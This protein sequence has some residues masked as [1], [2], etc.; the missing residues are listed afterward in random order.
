MPEEK[1]IGKRIA[2]G[3]F[4]M[5]AARWS[6]RGIGIISTIILARLLSPS[7]FGVVAISMLIVGFVEVLADTGLA[8]SLIRHPDPKPSHFNTVWTLQILLGALIAII[9]FI[10]APAAATYFG[11]DRLVAVIRL[12][13]LR[14]LLEGFENPGIIWFRRNMEFNMDFKLLVWR[15][16]I[17]FFLGIALAL[18]LRDYW[19]LVYAMISAKI[20]AVGLSYYF[21]P[22]RPRL[23]LSKVGDIWAFS[24]WMLIVQ[25]GDYLSRRIDEV[26]IGG[27]TGTQNV[28]LYSIATDVAQSPTLELTGPISRVLFSAYSKVLDQKEQ[29]VEIFILA[30]SSL[31]I[32]CFATG[33]GVAVVAEDLVLVILGEKWSPIITTL[34]WLALSGIALAL[35]INLVQFLAVL[36]KARVAALFAWCQ[37]ALLTPVVFHAAKTG[38][39]AEVG[40]GRLCVL[41]LVLGLALIP[42]SKITQIPLSRIVHSLWGPALASLLMSLCVMSTERFLPDPSIQRLLAKIAVGGLT[43]TAA[44]ICL[45]VLRG[46]RGG[47][48]EP[49]I[50]GVRKE[51]GAL[52]RRWLP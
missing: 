8:L 15:R 32:I 37:V 5:I 12:L 34:Q 30:F 13:S 17:R 51:F 25:I 41:I 44:T 39:I 28:G 52:K 9:L 46:R 36:G 43:Y 33:V 29:L 6:V 23:S 45:W 21:H 10:V 49:L 3:S 20:I 35:T 38:Q 40:F 31:S 50:R 1:S 48:E 2:S 26:A 4:W 14:A 24:L 47:L 16:M 18:I 22:F 27:A 11:D 42:F 7:D 19:A